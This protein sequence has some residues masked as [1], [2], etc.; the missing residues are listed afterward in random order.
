MTT[1]TTSSPRAGGKLAALAK[2]QRSGDR[3][4]LPLVEEHLLSV[5]GPDP[6]RDPRKVHVSEMA[7]KDWCE[8]AT[9]HRIQSG[10]WPA[11]KFSF[12]MSS[13]FDEGHQIHD[14]W[15]SWLAATGRLWGDWKCRS[16]DELV[17]RSR[18]DQLCE[19][20]YDA[21]TSHTHVWQY[22]EVSLAHGLVSGHE[23]GAVDDR[24]VEFKSVGIGTLRRDSPGLLAKYYKQTTEGKKLYDLDG[25]WTALKQPLMSHVKQTNIYLWLAGAMGGE[26]SRFNK[27]SIVYEYKPNQQ[28]REYVIPFSMDI[29]YPLLQRVDSI[30]TGL[31]RGV[32]PPC[33]YGGCKQCQAYGDHNQAKPVRRLVHRSSRGA[34]GG[35][36]PAAGVL[37]RRGGRLHGGECALVG[38]AGG[39][40]G[41]HLPG[42]EAS[43][44]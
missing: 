9:W 3:V 29:A 4:V 31:S 33:P 36:E 44:I 2:I 39:E 1:K 8:R 26:Y 13:I 16:C 25:L 43:K 19:G 24:L 37:L 18:A 38:E 17:L 12:A 23:D 5:W 22:A 21:G 7:K 6:D 27:A 32:P 30:A 14:K 20:W 34:D 28:S 41:A 40:L 11:E 15:Q 10:T 35:H 42:V